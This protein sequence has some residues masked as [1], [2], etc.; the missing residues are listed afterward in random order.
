M[1]VA[2]ASMEN[3]DGIL[4]PW[5]DDESRTLSRERL[6]LT[7][8]FLCLYGRVFDVH[9]SMTGSIIKIDEGGVIEQ[10]RVKHPEQPSGE[11]LVRQ[12]GAAYPSKQSVGCLLKPT[13]FISYHSENEVHILI[14]Y[15]SEGSLCFERVGQIS[16]HTWR[17]FYTKKLTLSTALS[18]WEEREVRIG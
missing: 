16:L 12:I 1:A 2:R 6:T 11:L 10:M 17:S 5:N 13:L 18:G 8:A 9:I 14:L 15:Q 3:T 7:L 4:L